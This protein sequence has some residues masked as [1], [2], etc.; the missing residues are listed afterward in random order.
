MRDHTK[1]KVFQLADSLALLVYERTAR[2]PREERFGLRSQLRRAAVSVAANI[3]EG[4][5]RPSDTD[6]ARMLAIAYGS[7]RELEYEISLAARLRYL[8]PA[9]AAE[10]L[11]VASQAGRA[12]RSLIRAVTNG[13]GAR[14]GARVGRRSSSG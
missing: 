9:D 5:A 11:N 1:L 2:F 8:Q 10:L 3:V 6:F 14:K 7:A 13:R 4:A 12:L